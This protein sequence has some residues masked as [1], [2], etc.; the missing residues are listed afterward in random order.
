MFARFDGAWLPVNQKF[1]GEARFFG[2]V[3]AFADRATRFTEYRRFAVDSA[4]RP[5]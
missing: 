2:I 1:R 3:S 4:F 5:E